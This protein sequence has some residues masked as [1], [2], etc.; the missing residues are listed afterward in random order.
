MPLLDGTSLLE[1]D[2]KGRRCWMERRLE[3]ASLLDGT[4][5]GRDVVTG[6]DIDWKGRRLEGTLLLLTVPIDAVVVDC[7]DQCCCC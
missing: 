3:G 6:W 4:S 2:W 7:S 5:I 1:G